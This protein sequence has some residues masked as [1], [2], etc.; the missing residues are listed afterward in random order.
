MLREACDDAV[1][2]VLLV[3]PENGR[4]GVVEDNN[5]WDL[6]DIILSKDANVRASLSIDFVA[7]PVWYSSF[8][9]QVPNNAGNVF[10]LSLKGLEAL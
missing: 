3:D 5:V 10:E 1:G 2:K 4:A 6:M 8:S 7:I 9:T